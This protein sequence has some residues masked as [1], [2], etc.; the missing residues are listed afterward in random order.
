M[1]A[2]KRKQKLLF[3]LS[4]T[5]KGLEKMD[6]DSFNSERAHV[7]GFV[8]DQRT[9]RHAP[10]RGGFMEQ[11]IWAGTSICNRSAAEVPVAGDRMTLSASKAAS[12][13]ATP[14]K[15]FATR[16]VRWLG[17]RQHFEVSRR[18]SN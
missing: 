12:S 10:I 7:S 11:R 6:V 18:V 8:S 17:E 3:A 1:D 15:L 2:Q 14:G 5:E 9:F 13:N 4:N 16:Q